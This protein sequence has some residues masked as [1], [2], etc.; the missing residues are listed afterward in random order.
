MEGK[1]ISKTN[2][3]ALCYKI[4]DSTDKSQPL[5]Q[6]EQFAHRGGILI[7]TAFYPCYHGYLSK[8]YYGGLIMVDYSLTDNFSSFRE[9][10][11]LDNQ[12]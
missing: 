8:V 3:K 1:F 4:R 12:G 10:W 2:A 7:L 6:L 5:W 11:K 9:L